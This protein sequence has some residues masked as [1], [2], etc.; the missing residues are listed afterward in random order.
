MNTSHLRF[1]RPSNQVRVKSA[2][3][4]IELLV[5][6]AIIAILA[7]ILFPVF[8]RARENARRS[9]CQSNLKQIGLGIAQYTQD[10]D[11]KYPAA[12]D[13]IAAF[14]QYSAQDGA[15]VD[16]VMP[17][18]KSQQIFKCP[19]AIANG[20]VSY[21]FNGFFTTTAYG[22][23]IPTSVSIAAVDSPTVTMMIREAA[24]KNALDT[25]YL[26]PPHTSGLNSDTVEAFYQQNTHFEGGN[27]LLAD[28][29]VKYYADTTMA[30]WKAK[31]EANTL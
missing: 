16:M 12:K 9:S 2:F 6:I 10:Y 13:A 8:G 27:L 4:L 15:W 24:N 21:F 5:V 23:G 20:P 17:Y 14:Q 18:I 29:H 19:S 31:F 26:R 7:A 11:E 25:A 1:G 22:G 30:G 28:G 3:T